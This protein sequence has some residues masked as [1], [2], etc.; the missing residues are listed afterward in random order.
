M[1]ALAGQQRPA[2]SAPGAVIGASV[3]VFAIAVAIVTVPHRAARRV[4]LEERVG[5]PDRIEDK[6]ISGA[7]QAE[8][9]QLQKLGP[10]QFVTWHAAT[11]GP[12]MDRDD[13]V[14]DLWPREDLHR[15]YEHVIARHAEPFCE[16]RAGDRCPTLDIIVPEI[17]ELERP[18]A[19]GRREQI[20]S[21][22]ESGDAEGES[23]RVDPGTLLPAIL[24]GGGAGARDE[25]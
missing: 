15:Q 11:L 17:G 3:I 14:N 16:R 25:A 2:A 5:N 22:N 13:L 1:A 20:G 10:D 8:T 7:A 12:V 23:K 4:G 6:R 9:N 21:G 24:F 18:V 19:R